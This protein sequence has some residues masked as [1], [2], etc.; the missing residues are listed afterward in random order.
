MAAS[1]EPEIQRCSLTS[2]I[3]Q[4]KCVGQDMEDLDLMDK[5]AAESSKCT[6]PCIVR[7]YY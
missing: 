1:A 2:S 7:L 5:P 3:L 6:D 4:L